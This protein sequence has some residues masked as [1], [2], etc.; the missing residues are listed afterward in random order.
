MPPYS[1]TSAFRSFSTPRSNTDSST[2]PTGQRDNIDHAIDWLGLREGLDGIL[3]GA[4]TQRPKPDPDCFLRAME[5]E[6]VTP[7]RTLIFEDSKIGLE[8]ARRSGAA[9]PGGIIMGRT[10]YRRQMAR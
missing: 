6:G 8:A 9:Y 4:D 3:C 5:A 1:T 2:R 7:D 10:T